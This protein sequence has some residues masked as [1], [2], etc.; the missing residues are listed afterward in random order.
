[1]G[2][3][4]LLLL[5]LP[6][7]AA[8]QPRKWLED[9]AGKSAEEKIYIHTSRDGYVAG[10]TI[11]FKAYI[12]SGLYPSTYSSSFHVQLSADSGMVLRHVFPVISGTSVG[13]IDLPSNLPEGRYFLSGSTNTSLRESGRLGYVQP[14]LVLNALS[15]RKA[16]QPS[17]TPKPAIRLHPGTS[18]PVS[19]VAN[20]LFISILDQH[21]QPI[22][23]TA[24]LLDGSNK[25]IA[26]AATN[27]AGAASFSFVPQKGAAYRVEAATASGKITESLPAAEDGTAMTVN[28]ENND[29]TVSVQSTPGLPQQK[30]TLL[31]EY[32]YNV[33]MEQPVPMVE[34]KGKLVVKTGQL[35]SG[36]IRLAL[37][38][39]NGEAV[40]ERFVFSN[41]SEALV[42][43][44]GKF[45]KDA[46]P[47]NQRFTLQFDEQVEGTLSM[48][49]SDTAN[50]IKTPFRRENIVNRFLFSAHLQEPVSFARGL[51]T[52]IGKTDLSLLN[53]ILA[54][55]PLTKQPWTSIRNGI[56]GS[57]LANDTDYVRIEGI[58]DAAS[59]KG[60][61]EN[62]ELNIIMSTS[63]SAQQIFVVPVD[64][65]GKF[66]LNGLI[67]TDTASMRYQLNSEK[68][69]GKR[70]E[71]TLTGHSLTGPLP[72]AD[73]QWNFT[74]Y[75]PPL[76]S[77]AEGD[78]RQLVQRVYTLPSESSEP[79]A[80]VVVTTTRTWREV[81]EESENRYFTGIFTTQG[82]RIMNF[83][84]DPPANGWLVDYLR[85]FDNQRFR[86]GDNSIISQS[87][88]LLVV[89]YQYFL[90]EAPTTFE[91][92]KTTRISDVAMV[93]VWA[94]GFVG[95]ESRKPA[96]A[97]YTRKHD[98]RLPNQVD[99]LKSL[100]IAGYTPTKD[101]ELPTKDNKKNAYRYLSTFYWNP[102]LLIDTEGRRISSSFYNINESKGKVVVEGMTS[103]GRLVYHE[104]TM[105]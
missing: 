16:G 18:K 12:M 79:L 46:K 4:L 74:G 73:D 82:T 65:D 55:Q 86:V 40:A 50:G 11:Y 59:K 27:D 32:E 31:A 60:L 48:Q 100:K 52:D 26:T 39:A 6:F 94:S 85:R 75:F 83:L 29:Y 70:A 1:M 56:P 15:N 24:S 2:K 72:V 3:T 76:A 66:V 57:K 35:P 53:S 8:A 98:D 87:S 44:K 80:E 67:F 64:K 92:L 33:L 91:M 49:I 9:A 36:I 19:G 10:E 97:V 95:S 69:K 103:E 88:M 102:Y 99:V 93:K 23:T 37:L 78:N 22:K 61:G 7:A 5:L 28:R 96:I 89:E 104:G 43:G 77:V 13:S 30:L 84:T 54:T 68:F 34:N 62:R 90:D 101:F 20:E 105:N 38:N 21:H 47:E 81:K 51:I 17:Y 45:E 41:N 14:L 25:V 42:Q 63:D 71:V 58:V